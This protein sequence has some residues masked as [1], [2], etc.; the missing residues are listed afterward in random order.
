[1]NWHSGDTVKKL[2]QELEDVTMEDRFLE[3]A[4]VA[5]ERGVTPGMVRRDAEMGR[6]RTAAKTV[7]GGRL[8]RIEDVR[9]YVR[10]CEARRAQRS[11]NGGRP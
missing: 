11:A 2:T 4:D 9:A 8:Y 3:G 1:M 6:L 5:R 7:R 10:E